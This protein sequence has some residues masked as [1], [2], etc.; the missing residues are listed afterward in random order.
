MAPFAEAERGWVKIG[1]IT[2]RPFGALL[3]YHVFPCPILCMPS[4]SIR[5]E[6]SRAG[7]PGRGLRYGELGAGGCLNRGDDIPYRR[8]DERQTRLLR[9][10]TRRGC[11]VG[12]F[13]LQISRATRDVQVIR[14]LDRQWGIG[15]IFL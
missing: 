15:R 9:I 12:K 13:R 10:G 1:I 7:S 6:P 11:Q 2:S 14:E 4:R 3:S 8:K 5:Q